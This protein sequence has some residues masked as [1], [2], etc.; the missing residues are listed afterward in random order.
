[1]KKIT[2][3]LLGILLSALMGCGD[4]DSKK[5]IE[6]KIHEL[7]AD[8]QDIYGKEPNQHIFSKDLV[9]RIK[10]QQDKTQKDKER[11]KNSP[12]PTDKPAILEGSVFTSLP[13]GFSKYLVKNISI[14]DNTAEAL[15]EFEYPSEPKE[16]WTDKI[17]LVQ[18]NGWKIDNILFSEKFKGDKDLKQ[19]L[20]R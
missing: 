18:E 6:E 14:S 19:R 10:F 11:I 2:F 4:T 9:G 16:T 1:M 5:E 15:V 20:S 12:F 7:Y 17:M 3:L 8:P 13:D